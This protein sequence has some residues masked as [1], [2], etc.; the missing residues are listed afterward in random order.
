MVEIDASDLRYG[1][2]WKQKLLERASSQISFRYLA[3]FQKKFSIVLCL[4]KFQ[5]DFFNKKFLIRSDRKATPNALTKDVQNLV[6]K[7]I[8]VRWQAL[9]SYFGFEIEHIKGKDNSLPDFLT[10]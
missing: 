9:L 2:I 7:H 4:Q 1:G 6:S 8:F 3:F 5:D 10:R